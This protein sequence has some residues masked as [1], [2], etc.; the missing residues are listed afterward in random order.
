MNFRSL[1]LAARAY[2]LAVILM[3]VIL[4]G[5]SLASWLANGYRMDHWRMFAAL[6]AASVVINT[7]KIKVT[8]AASTF[9]IGYA[10][11]FAALLLLGTTGALWIVMAGAYAQCTVRVKVQSPW[12]QTAFSIS[13]L[14]LAL[15]AAGFVLYRTGG[16]SVSGPAD[17][18]IPS[19]MAA[20]L[21]YFLTNSMLMAT[22]IALTT[23][24]TPMQVWD[25]DFLWGAPN[26]FIGALV[27]TVAVQ[28]STRFGLTS[29]IILAA[30]GFLTFRIYIVYVR[31][32]DEALTDP[33][34]RLPNRRSLAS[35]ADT[36]IA[37]ASRAV[38][39]FAV[40]MADV[41]RFK[42]VNDTYGHQKGDEL[43]GLIADGFRRN[44]RP[45]D[46][47][48]RYAGDEFVLILPGCTADL[49]AERANAIAKTIAESPLT[50]ANGETSPVSV[51]LGVAAFPADGKTYEDL[52]AVA[53]ARMYRRKAQSKKAR[54]ATIGATE[55]TP[56]TSY[57]H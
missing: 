34:T 39:P 51:S 37:R 46:F 8:G 14:A 26:Y 17:A 3:A 42:L 6:L 12:Y 30:L 22:V 25:H 20:S 1:P 15:A 19:I 23:A 32:L 2:I 43:L 53:D 38:Q 16:N 48:A 10:V 18:V 11:S 35:H 7:I 28:S 5:V 49:A 47:C 44:L 41:D 36:E 55:T 13:V 56:D 40:V 57:S 27:A 24:R 54:E 4:A 31:Q 52:L 29:V 50:L 9:S 33:L 21:A 45:Y